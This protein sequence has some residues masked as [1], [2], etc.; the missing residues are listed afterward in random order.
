[1]LSKEKCVFWKI[2]FA[3]S[4]LFFCFF[5]YAH[6]S[7]GETRKFRIGYIEAGQ[8]W[9]FTGTLNATKD[10]LA[11]MG[12]L[13]KVE[14]P[15]DAHFSPGWEPEKKEELQSDARKLMARTDLDLVI[16][17]GTDAT[18]AI[19]A[20]NNGR[21]PII[22]IAISDPIRA[23]FIINENDSGID[24]FT[25]YMEKDRYRRM[26]RMFH[27]VVGFKKLGLIYS[28][29]ENGRLFANVDDGL[30]IAAERGFQ[31]VEYT[32][33]SRAEKTEECL[34]GIR[35]LIKQGIEAFFITQ[36]NCYDWSAS[37]VKQLL[38]E[39]SDNKI[40]T[41][42]R[43]GTKY[44]KAGALMG[45]STT[46]FTS[47]GNFLSDKI[48]RIFQGEKPRSLPMVDPTKP[49]ISLNLATAMKIGFDPP[50]DLLGSS[51]E[52]FQEVTLPE[53]RLVK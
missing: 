20:V 2:A 28:D 8:F 1:M 25:V 49:K 53:D 52:I 44:V 34:E 22:G 11:R 27:E 30:Q 14:F 3:F 26:F 43:E 31:I 6:Q 4:L 12:W 42:A 24:N 39:L 41:F 19:L 51:D 47:R 38:D 37:D 36:I 32:K 35:S 29:T 46:D 45:F 48:V 17:A 15:R 16:A 10:A 9:T 7:T 13:D 5:I 40:P 33:V 18:K 21:T 50:V 23:K